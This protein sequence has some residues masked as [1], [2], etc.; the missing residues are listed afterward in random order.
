MGRLGNDGSGSGTGST[1]HTGGNEGHFGVGGQKC[2]DVV[3]TF[4]GGAFPDFGVGAGA[5]AFRQ[6]LT[7]LDLRLHGAVLQRLC[8]GVAN[9][10][11][12][13]VDAGQFHEVDRIAAASAYA[14]D[15]DHGRAVFG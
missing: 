6:T 5:Q 3:H 8:V 11:I 1:A 4:D 12:N 7:Q 9:H 2:F 14:N 13:A 15:L 10:K